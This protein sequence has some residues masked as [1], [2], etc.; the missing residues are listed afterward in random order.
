VTVCE[1]SLSSLVPPLSSGSSQ[2][3]AKLLLGG[4]RAPLVL[5]GLLGARRADDHPHVPE[6]RH[7]LGIGIDCPDR[8]VCSDR[9]HRMASFR[10]T[11]R[12]TSAQSAAARLWRWQG[13]AVRWL[14]RVLA[15]QFVSASASEHSVEIEVILR[16]ASRGPLARHRGTLG[17]S[18]SSRERLRTLG[19]E[20]RTRAT[21][22]RATPLHA[23]HCSR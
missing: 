15:L 12:R 19:G 9:R 13:N 18:K 22:N 14:C 20:L 6:D 10:Y 11:G 23:P 21:G 16:P 3:L 17:F 1:D 5:A 8:S 7:Q 4:S 2:T